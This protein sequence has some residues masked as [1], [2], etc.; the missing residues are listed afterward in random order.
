MTAPMSSSRVSAGAGSGEVAGIQLG[1][2]L[3]AGRD[4]TGRPIQTKTTNDTTISPAAIWAGLCLRNPN[5]RLAAEAIPQRDHDHP[6]P[7]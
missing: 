2:T 1:A 6:D 7:P 3:A 5:D 4:G